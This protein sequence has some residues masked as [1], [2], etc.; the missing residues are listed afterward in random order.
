L[1][2]Q[3]AAASAAWDTASDF[4]LLLTD[5]PGQEAYPIVAT[6]FIL[7]HKKTSPHRTR[8]ALDFFGWSLG[9]GAKAAAELGYVPLP[10]GLI[11]Q[12]KNIGQR[13]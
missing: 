5:T 12:A 7:M 9:K 11:T 2:F 8:A 10:Q 4:D 6:V 13:I 1:S 3:A